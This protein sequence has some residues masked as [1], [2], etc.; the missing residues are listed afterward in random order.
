M[1]ARFWLIAATAAGIVAA[2]A[3]ASA[4][5]RSCPHPES[6]R[7]NITRSLQSA[8]TCQR[9][10]DMMNACRS[11]T[12]GDVELA[13]VVIQ[14]CEASFLPGL[15]AA[16]RRT[17]DTERAACRNKYAKREGTMY[18]SFTVTCEAGVAARLAG[19]A[20]KRSRSR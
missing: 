7:D 10:Y 4:Q 5:Q 16:A 12:G 8:G 9:A 17:Y 19:V 11:N 14:R 13:E 18:V 20:E 3:P 1:N 15:S 6:D 2:M